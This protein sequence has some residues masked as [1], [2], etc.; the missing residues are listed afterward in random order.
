MEVSDSTRGTKKNSRERER[1]SARRRAGERDA[2]ERRGPEPREERVARESNPNERYAAEA[3][4][5]G[6]EDGEEPE[7]NC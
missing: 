3:S 1:E 6:E 5:D 7:S 2:I 4:E